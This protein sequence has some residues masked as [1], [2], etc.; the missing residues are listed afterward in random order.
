MLFVCHYDKAV[1]LDRKMTMSVLVVI[2]IH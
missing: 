1:V 2:F